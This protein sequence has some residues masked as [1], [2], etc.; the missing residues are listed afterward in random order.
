[1]KSRLRTSSDLRRVLEQFPRRGEV[2]ILA[3][4]R[5]DGD[6]IGSMLGLAAA[7]EEA[8]LR[9]VRLCPDPVPEVYRF[10][11]GAD[12]VRSR[13]PARL[14][15]VAVA[16]DCDATHRLAKFEQALP[17]FKTLID[18]DHHS[19]QQPFGTAA[20]IDPG[21]SS[22][23]EMVYVVLKRLQI[24]I[25]PEAATCLYTAI[26]TDT[27]RFCYQNTTAKSLRVAAELVEAG[28][29]PAHVAVHVYEAKPLGAVRL[30]GRA[31]R[32]LKVE[33]AGRFVSS[34]L[35]LSDFG[36]AGASPEDTEGIIDH[37][38]AIKGAEVAVLLSEQR[39]G[40]VRVSLR[41][42]GR[43]NVA[44]VAGM[45]GGGG[46]LYA[47]GCILDGPL[48][49]AYRRLMRAVRAAAASA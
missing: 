10:L 27:G 45:F 47:A 9:A 41:S 32:N 3:H 20:W 21:A 7:V 13:L 48:S 4:M 34:R 5:P 2:A 30:V 42:R 22:V 29:D 16:L 36:A 37:L 24:P 28:A 38:R 33:N 26:V 40:K 49:T 39:D 19:G 1:M 17:R 43:L 35:T 14:P 8:G 31:L 46:H 12:L 6:A 23:G 18:I 15:K 11:P 25:G 44:A